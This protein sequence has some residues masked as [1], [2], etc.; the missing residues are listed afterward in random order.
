MAT[1]STIAIQNLDGTVQQIYCHW[2]GYISYNGEILKKHYNT[3]EKV[4]G[5]IALGDLSSLAPK[6]SGG[7][8][9]SFETPEDDVCVA[10]GRDRGEENTA[11][12]TFRDFD[13][14]LFDM[15]KEEYDYLFVEGARRWYLVK[16]KQLLTFLTELDDVELQKTKLKILQESSVL[17]TVYSNVLKGEMTYKDFVDVIYALVD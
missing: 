3:A 15:A 9:H 11:A 8:G 4:R 6:L 10:Y 2:D 12:R 7:E 14:F 5:L 13:S 17:K 16:N 1:R